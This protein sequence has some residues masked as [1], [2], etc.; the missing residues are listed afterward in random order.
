[1]QSNMLNQFE[2][3]ETEQEATRFAS[4]SLSA[5]QEQ[6]TQSVPIFR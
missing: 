6:M 1:M 2:S 5:L 4:A 3:T